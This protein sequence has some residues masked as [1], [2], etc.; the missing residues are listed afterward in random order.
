M[1][2]LRCY[3]AC[4]C[5]L[6]TLYHRIDVDNSTLNSNVCLHIHL[7]E[8]PAKLKYVQFTY[9]EKNQ[10][11]SIEWNGSMLVNGTNCYDDVI[12]CN[13]QVAVVTALGDVSVTSEWVSVPTNPC[14]ING[15]DITT[16]GKYVCLCV[17]CS[18]CQ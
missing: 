8:S 10:V 12:G 13:V 17:Y 6:N 14:P 18:Y 5:V 7:P 9:T 2:Y 15:P 16:I 11:Q 3:L 1:D 4:T